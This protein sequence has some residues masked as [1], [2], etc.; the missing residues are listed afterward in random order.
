MGSWGTSAG[1]GHDP[2]NGPRKDSSEGIEGTA[3][4]GDEGALGPK[5]GMAMGMLPI[6]G[7]RS[8]NGPEEVREG[9]SVSDRDPVPRTK[10]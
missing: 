1:A 9:C 6:L 7:L 8:A 3:D 10:K 5:D 4:G 2:T